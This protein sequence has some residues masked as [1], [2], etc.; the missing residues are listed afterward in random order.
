MQNNKII[1]ILGPT[2]S[3]K[4]DLAVTLAQKYNGEIISADSRQVYK[5]LNIGSGKITK[6]EMKNIPHYLLDILKPQRNFSVG[7]FKK[8][9]DKIIEDILKRGKLPILVGGTGFYIQAV[10]AGIILPEVKANLVLR[11]DLALR[12]PSELFLMLKRVD[13]ERAKNIDAKN[14]R[15]LIR[16]IEIATDLGKVP[17]LKLLGSHTANWEVLQIGVKTDQGILNKRIEK[18]FYKRVKAGIV[19]EAE[20]LHK[21]GLTYKRMLEIGLAHKYIPLLL[22]NKIS[23]QEF[24]DNS[25]KEEQKYAKRQRTWFKKDKRIEWFELGDLKNI[26]KRISNFLKN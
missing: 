21:K 1:V 6:K 13:P 16:A 3:G 24:I 22:K 8:K 11:K 5:G 19:K 9:A 12:A 17:S 26:N 20:N 14:P 7:Q 4:S 23:Q 10:V 18:R 25:I 15:R 2:A